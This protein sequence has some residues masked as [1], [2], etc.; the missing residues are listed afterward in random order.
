VSDEPLKIPVQAEGVPEAAS[1]LDRVTA[2]LRGIAG[3]ARQAVA[4]NEDSRKSFEEF[5]TTATGGASAAFD[6]FS[7]W[8][9]QIEALGE[10]IAELTAEQQQLDAASSRLGLDFNAAADAAGRFVDETEAMH[11]ASVLAEAGL[12]LT[13]NQIDQLSARAAI[14]SQ[15]LGIDNTDA[16]NRLTQA[17]ITGS[18]RALRPLGED[19][20]ALGGTAHT[21]TERLDA[22]VST[23]EGMPRATD[24][25]TTSVARFRDS[26]EDA[27]R[28]MAHAA[29][30]SFVALLT[31]Q[32]NLSHGARESGDSVADTTAKLRAL[33]SAAGETA[34]TVMRAMQGL[35]G[36]IV[37]ALVAP[38]SIFGSLLSALHMAEAGNF[39]GAAAE[40][41]GIGSTGVLGEALANAREGTRGAFELLSGDVTPDNPAGASVRSAITRGTGAAPAGPT[42]WH[43]AEGQDTDPAQSA[44]TASAIREAM[45][46]RTVRE[47][48]ADH[49][50]GSGGRQREASSDPNALD[51]LF[52][53]AFGHGNEAA[54][55][56]DLMDRFGASASTS[57]TRSR[58]DENAALTPLEQRRAQAGAEQERRTL[59]QRYQAQRAFTDRW[60]ELHERQTSAAQHAAEGISGAFD[61]LGKAL[62]NHFAAVVAGRESVG[63]ALQGVLA[64]TLTS[65]G[66]E[67]A[68]KGG[69]ETAEGIAAL[70]GIYTAGLAPGHFAAAGAYFGVAA[71]AGAAG[72][73]LTPSSG[74]ASGGGS[75][76]PAR[77]R[78][79]TSPTGVT[80]PAA[81][82]IVQNYYAPTFGGRE[83]TRAEVGDRMNRFTRASEARLQR[84]S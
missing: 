28:T 3:A 39:S 71:L 42:G 68:V 2:A 4:A 40:L 43:T 21:A 64:D 59:D 35:G 58:L 74:G 38:A 47:A 36:A 34:L 46:R 32:T 60:T 24:D 11:A 27:E 66:K 73:A 82:T 51:N 23:T 78:A 9:G 63:Q 6:S 53:R 19:M 56:D 31:A 20:A 18:E 57:T 52:D 15:R 44:R 76:S 41:R 30:T 77:E 75:A 48:T 69:M 1:A 61:S 84:S 37:A 45:A 80:T 49:R 17:V 8:A 16:F 67:A 55:I 50:G 81:P 5:L 13:Q 14:L 10:K 70:A 7:R 33:G 54:S 72:A 62:G 25:A 22:L 83:G 29:S 12:H 65:V 79:A 26:I